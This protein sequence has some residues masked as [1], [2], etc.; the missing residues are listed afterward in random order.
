MLPAIPDL[1][2]FFQAFFEKLSKFLPYIPI[3]LYLGAAQHRHT[4]FLESQQLQRL[5]IPKMQCPLFDCLQCVVTD[6][7]TSSEAG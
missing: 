3:L 7:A 5:S 2:Q 1:I 6:K 4:C